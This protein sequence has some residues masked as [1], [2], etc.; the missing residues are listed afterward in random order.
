MANHTERNREAYWQ[1]LE[2]RTGHHLGR[3]MPQTR[4]AD[5]AP[6]IGITTAF[7]MA[8]D[9]ECYVVK[10]RKRPTNSAVA[11]PVFGDK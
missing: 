5:N 11:A 3:Y 1:V 7:R 9:P 8:E 6:V 10:D 2:D 4:W